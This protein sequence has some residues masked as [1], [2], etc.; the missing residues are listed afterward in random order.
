MIGVLFS[1]CFINK[2]ADIIIMLD[3][4][5]NQSRA[6]FTA[7]QKSIEKLITKAAVINPDLLFGLL[8]Y[9][10]EPDMVFN[11]SWSTDK[12]K[13]I[14]ALLQVDRDRFNS[15]KN[16]S[17]ALEFIRTGS[18]KWSSRQN[19]TN[20]IVLVTN[21]HLPDSEEVKKEIHRLK[22]IGV[23]VFAIATGNDAL[24]RNLYDILLYPNNLFY[25]SP[26]E[27]SDLDVLV[28]FTMSIK[29]T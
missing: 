17:H 24:H 25:V 1:E 15:P 21:G 11:V 13:M 14:S 6:D 3:T 7:R 12:H 5:G 2:E 10:D 9:S 19:S 18:M 20:F 22:L 26:N 29:C 16:T 28:A 27:F 23:T 8:Q 4:S